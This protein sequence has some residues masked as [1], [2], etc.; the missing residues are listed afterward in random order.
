MSTK[1]ANKENEGTAG[2]N[3]SLNKNVIIFSTDM[4][5]EMRQSIIQVAQRAFHAP[6]NHGKVYQTIADL[7]RTECEKECDGA[8][9]GDG[10]KGGNESSGGAGNGSGGKTV[11]SGGWSCVVGDAFGS[12]VTHR[13]KTYIHFSVVPGVNVLLWKS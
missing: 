4:S 8:G 7:I 12:S 2:A 13:M 5:E 11:G 1:D 3:P 10:S 6:V 9:S